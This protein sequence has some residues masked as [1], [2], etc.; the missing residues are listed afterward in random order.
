MPTT[1]PASSRPNGRPRQRWRRPSAFVAAVALLVGVAAACEP[2]P[3][4]TT[5]PGWLLVDRADVTALGPHVELEWDAAYGS[6]TRYRIDVNGVTATVVDPTA[7]R[8][9]MVGLAANTAHTFRITAYDA[10]GNWSDS[11]PIDGHHDPGFRPAAYTPPSGPSGGPTRRCVPPT[12]TDLDR[13]P[14][15][16]ETGTGTFA[17]TGST[18]S[19]PTIAD[20]DDDGIDDGDEVLGTPGGLDLYALGARP[21]R[22]DLIV[23]VDWL[24]G[25]TAPGRT[26]CSSVPNLQP[27]AARVQGAIDVYADFPSS[28]P[29]GGQGINLIVDRG[30][31]GAFTGGNAVPDED[32]RLDSN[33]AKAAHMAA[34]RV[35]Y[36][37]YAIN[38]IDFYI[39]LQGYFTGGLAPRPGDRVAIG[40]GCGSGTSDFNLNAVLAHELGHNGYL[41]H[42]G[43]DSV[44]GKPNY[45]SLM[46]Y[47]FGYAADLNC[48]GE[49][50]YVPSSSRELR[51][52]DVVQPPIDEAA[53]REWLGVCEDGTDAD[54]DRDGVIDVT[55]YSYDVSGNGVIE[56]LHGSDDGE[57]L[58]LALAWPRHRSGGPDGEEVY[59][60]LP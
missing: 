6:P 5:P 1:T 39:F 33:T 35:G 11:L 43:H 7:T 8:C 60:P 13:L 21:Q 28:T 41:H 45:N 54:L 44:N 55:P 9:V 50:D 12:D 52:S 19:S 59:D 31:G 27:T 48:D 57:N 37:H 38:V 15:A 2:L 46:N 30:Q 47:R 18:G 53:I 16:L 26:S 25:I 42:G 17:H 51:W 23:E 10:A 3:P 58:D 20:S 49:P 22:R 4:D 32:G 24:T 56:V 36:V 34:N 14:D 40:H 29:L